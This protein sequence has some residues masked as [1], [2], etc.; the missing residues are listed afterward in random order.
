MQPFSVYIDFFQKTLSRLPVFIF[1]LPLL[2]FLQ[3]TEWEIWCSKIAWYKLG[4]KHLD[5][6]SWID[7]SVGLVNDEKCLKRSESS[8]E[9]K[10]ESFD[11]FITTS[12][13]NVAI[14]CP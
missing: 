7:F 2:Q 11:D 1:R 3:L 4:P 9:K 13:L 10:L 8:A 5:H 6:S 14:G 12:Q